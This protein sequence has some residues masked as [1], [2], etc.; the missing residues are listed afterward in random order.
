MIHIH[1]PVPKY[2]TGLDVSAGRHDYDP[3][4]HI[5]T[6]RHSLHDDHYSHPH[7]RILDYIVRRAIA[8]RRG[9]RLRI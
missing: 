9:A 5:T 3:A 7:I 2:L 1:S 8:F 6:V 4:L